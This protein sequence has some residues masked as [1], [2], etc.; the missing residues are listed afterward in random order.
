MNLCVSLTMEAENT[1]ALDLHRYSN[2][3][4]S[5]VVPKIPLYARYI[6]TPIN[7]LFFFLLHLKSYRILNLLTIAPVFI[8]NPVLFTPENV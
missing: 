3:G 4:H 6:H 5:Q 1:E 2:V 8:S 7:H